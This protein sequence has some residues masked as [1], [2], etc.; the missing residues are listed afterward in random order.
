MLPSNNRSEDP[1]LD[2]VTQSGVGSGGGA[3]SFVP[4]FLLHHI[5]FD[6]GLVD[7]LGPDQPRLQGNLLS[8]KTGVFSHTTQCAQVT[9][10]GP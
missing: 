7:G 1:S 5:I 10:L 4:R 3:C 2:A 9:F 6:H 8:S